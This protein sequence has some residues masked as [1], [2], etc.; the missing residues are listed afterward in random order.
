MRIPFIRCTAVLL[1]FLFSSTALFS[2]TSGAVVL[3]P[4]EAVPYG[5]AEFP[6]WQLDLRR[7]EIIAFGSLPF[8]TFL[9]SIGYDVYRYYSH[10]QQEGYLPW[11]LKNK[12][13]A[14]PLS[15]DEQKNVL[16][17]AVGISVGIALTDLVFRLIKRNQ[18]VRHRERE[19]AGTVTIERID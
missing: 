12:A 16:L 17:T 9:G 1:F 4:G 6:Q 11:P 5:P 14:I 8:V 7:G 3:A 18:T 15:E 2:Q 10:D 19:A 13:T